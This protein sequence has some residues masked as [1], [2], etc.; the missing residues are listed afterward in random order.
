LA[1]IK[2]IKLTNLPW[3]KIVFYS[4]ITS[5]VLGVLIYYF[6]KNGGDADF[7]RPILNSIH[8]NNEQALNFLTKQFNEIEKRDKLLVH[9]I[10][11]LILNLAVVKNLLQNYNK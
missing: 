10:N 8:D 11:D 1:G 9:A 2:A 5:A 3:G 7:F 6:G 4:L